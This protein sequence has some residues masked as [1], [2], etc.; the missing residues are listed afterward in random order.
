MAGGGGAVAGGFMTAI[1]SMAAAAVWD[2]ILE[3]ALNQAAHGLADAYVTS[4]AVD[5]IY[6]KCA[7]IALVPLN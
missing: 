3:P 6:A 7:G 4:L 1:A 2:P 5:E